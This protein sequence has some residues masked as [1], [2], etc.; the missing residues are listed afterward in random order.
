VNPS[1]A[2][3]DSQSLTAD[4]ETK[5]TEKTKTRFGDRRERVIALLDITFSFS[6]NHVLVQT[7]N[8]VNSDP[9]RSHFYSKTIIVLGR[10]DGG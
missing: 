10:D 8:A 1:P 5:D 9:K 6:Q 7:K 3:L 2:I 4:C